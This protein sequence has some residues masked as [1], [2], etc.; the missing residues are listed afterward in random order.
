MLPFCFGLLA[1]WG[2]GMED[3]KGLTPAER[4]KADVESMRMVGRSLPKL[5]RPGAEERRQTV[6]RNEAIAEAKR[7]FW[8]A[9]PD[10]TAALLDGAKKGKATHLKMVMELGGLAPGTFSVR[11]VKVQVE[12]PGGGDDSAMG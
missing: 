6:R 9:L 4:A 5:A 1:A 2:L 3:E 8:R 11:T 12:E 10:V 7:E